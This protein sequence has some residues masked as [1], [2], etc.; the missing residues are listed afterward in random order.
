MSPRLAF[1]IETAYAAGRSTLALFETGAAVDLKSDVT[2][3][4]E[5]DRHAEEIVRAKIEAKY[6]GESVLGEEQGLT[7]AGDDRWVV[8]PIDGTKAFVC[9]VPTYAT[10]LAYEVDARPIL[11]VCY[12][13][14]LDIM[15]YAET[16]GGT[17]WN[18]RGV[19]ASEVTS[20]AHAALA[21]GGHSNM[22]KTDRWRGFETLI[23]K[24]MTTR[25]WQDAYGHC[26]VA[27]GRIAGMIDPTVSLWDISAMIPIVREAGALATDFD[28]NEPLARPMESLEMVSAAPGVG[29]EILAAFQ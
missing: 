6:P 11:G 15:V 12:L 25:T 20:L 2:P 28:G 27:A 21:C 1:A 16:G 19:R 3:V 24:T 13:P 5:A 9:G 18:G 10:L 4:T 7:G 26:L 22:I 17:F 29:A 8:D 14:A 23:A